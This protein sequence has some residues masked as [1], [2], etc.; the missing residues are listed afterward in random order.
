MNYIMNIYL[1]LFV[2]YLNKI[3]NIKYVFFIEIFS[4]EK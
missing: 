4:D 2:Q 3:L 1:Y